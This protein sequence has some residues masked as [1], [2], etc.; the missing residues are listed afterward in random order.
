MSKPI[1]QNISVFDATQVKTI[2]ASW[3]G[4]QIFKNRLI[5][6]NTSTGLE[7]YNNI[8]TSVRTYR[9]IP[10]NTLTNGVNYTAQMSFF[11]ADNNESTLSDTVFFQCMNAPLFAFANVDSRVKNSSLN[12]T[13]SFSQAQGD[14]LK[15]Y[16]FLLY[17]STKTNTLIDF[18]GYN[19]GNEISYKYTGLENKTTYYIRCIGKSVAGFDVDTGYVQITTSFQNP[20]A[21]YTFTAECDKSKG[22][23][24]YHTNIVVIQDTSGKT[25]RYKYGGIDLYNSEVIYSTGFLLPEDFVLEFEIAKPKL[26]TEVFRGTSKNDKNKF[27]AV[28]IVDGSASGKY[29]A[30]LSVVNGLS[31]YTLYSSEYSVGSKDTMTVYLKRVINSYSLNMK[32]N[33]NVI[34]SAGLYFGSTKPSSPVEGTEYIGKSDLT[35]VK[36]DETAQNIFFTKSSPTT[37]VAYDIFIKNNTTLSGK[38]YTSATTPPLVTDIT[39]VTI[40][41]AYFKKLY[42]TSNTETVITDS[43]PTTFDYD[44]VMLALFAHDTMAGNVGFAVETVS[45]LLIKRREVGQFNWVTIYK[46]NINTVD[47]FNISAVDYYARS[48]AKYQYAVVPTQNGIEGSYNITDVNTR[49]DGVYLADKDNIW[50]TVF[51]TGD[52]APTHVQKSGLVELQNRAKPIVV[53]NSKVNYEQGNASGYFAPYDELTDSID[54]DDCVP[55]QNEFKD[56]LANQCPKIL[57]DSVGHI[58]MV[59]VNENITDTENGHPDFRIISFPWTE[60]GECDSEQDLYNLGLSDVDSSDWS[61]NYE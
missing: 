49:F 44:T 38:T 8:E 17:D 15:E 32:V 47:D 12:A 27:F 56:F 42:I 26:N 43:M 3:D 45:K 39:T 34:T 6:K 29:K 11:D 61:K 46:Q 35:T 52:L 28:S 21:Y 58:Y 33:T 14:L 37:N 54:V 19:A 13:I 57:K 23:V 41:M 40:G 18:N 30:K 51:E 50:G 9:D 2:Y 22:T 53:F 25:F 31:A 16:T 1:I 4:F 7:V 10:A 48:R 36:I 59:S 5:I 60:V 20:D 55:Y 24:S